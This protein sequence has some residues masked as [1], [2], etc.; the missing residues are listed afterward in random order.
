MIDRGL[1]RGVVAL[2]AAGLLVGL[3]GVPAGAQPDLASARAQ[4]K[5]LA[6]Q[7]AALETRTEVATE[8]FNTINDQLQTVVTQM[9]E[10][11]Q[12]V[13]AAK[14]GAIAEDN[15]AQG[16]VRALYMSGGSI[17]LYASVLDSGSIGDVLS[18]VDRV[19]S[20]VDNDRVE[21]AQSWSTVSKAEKAR[22]KLGALA[23]KRTKLQD[24]ADAARSTVEVLLTQRTKQLTAA[25]ATVRRLADEYA[26]RKTR[27]AAES[28]RVRLMDL[29]VLG[30][31]AAGNPYATAAIAAA[32]SKVGS[33]YVWGAT[34]PGTFDCS[35]LTQWA[36]AQAGLSIDRT[37]RQQWFN[38]VAVPLSDLRPGDLIFWAYNLSQPGSIHHVA[39]YLGAGRM[40]EAP[41][42]GLDV[43]E[44]PVYLDG[45]IGAVRPGTS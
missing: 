8:N 24:Q 43:R 42:T 37:S 44:V 45:F 10:A 29:G 38:G 39:M 13:D 19:N 16:R 9:T 23:A 30:D 22:K 20:L 15:V 34:G 35:G 21:A 17:A 1:R 28:A 4:A 2:T 32:R 5:V 7:V 3:M 36:Y 33:P 31:Q 41:R 14:A 12:Q 11:E 40:I 27:Q 25:N 18:R 6:T 26:A